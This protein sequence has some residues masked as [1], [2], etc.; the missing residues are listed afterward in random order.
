MARLS[1]LLALGIAVVA[2]GCGGGDDGPRTVVETT[3]VTESAPETDT[4][5]ESTTD[6]EEPLEPE[7]TTPEERG[8]CT[9]ATGNEI[10]I[11]TGEVDCAAAK[12]TAAQYD[13]QG[14]RVQ[15]VGQFV[16]E[17]G[18]A[19]TRPV[20]FTCTGPGGEFVVSEAGG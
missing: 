17:G 7:T 15:E 19:Q 11:V 20:I 5:P 1:T 6:P 8:G 10:E 12:D 14:A 4:G 16:C 13:L 18:N 3:T 2:A 9:D